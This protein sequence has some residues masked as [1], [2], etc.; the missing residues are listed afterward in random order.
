[1]ALFPDLDPI[2]CKTSFLGRIIMAHSVNASLQC[3]F[4]SFF[5]LGSSVNK[6]P[7]LFTSLGDCERACSQ[8]GLKT[9]SFL[10]HWAE[11]KRLLQCLQDSVY[12]NLSSDDARNSTGMKLYIGSPGTQVAAGGGVSQRHGFSS[13]VSCNSSFVHRGRNLSQLPQ[14]THVEGRR[15]I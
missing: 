2:F 11:K 3:A 6:Q 14:V 7:L 10:C 15:W 9:S 12:R 8:R 5:A 4:C 13:K 1:M